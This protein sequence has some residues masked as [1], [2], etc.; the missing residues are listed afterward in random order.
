MKLSQLNKLLI[1]S[2]YLSILLH[3]LTILVIIYLIYDRYSY[4][5][6]YYINRYLFYSMLT[7][8]PSSHRNLLLFS[9]STLPKLGKNEHLGFGRPIIKKFLEP[10]NVKEILFITYA[11]PNV[12][13]GENTH[14]ADK[15]FNDL[16][17]PSFGKIG[18]KVKLL[19]TNSSAANQQQEIKNAQAVY[20]CGG[21]TF[22]LTQSL[23]K[24][25]VLQVL[26]ERI[27]SG[28]PYISASAGTNVTCPTMQTTND[29]PIACLN[30]CDT[31]NVIPFQMN[32]HYNEFKNKP[33][34]AAESRTQ[35]LCEY[36]QQNRLFKE[37]ETPTF[38][39]GLRE[40]SILHVSGDKAELLGLQSRKAVLMYLNNG[41]LNKTSI[42]IGER[43]DDLLK[44]KI[45][46]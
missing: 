25:G 46:V 3:I 9:S 35:R 11:S 45:S 29:M 6:E 39:L 20:M 38:I 28:M 1:K 37:T 33:G 44:L 41:V 22:L 5:P 36:L 43:V 34:F 42:N 17:V 30:S 26:K 10:H 4:I 23:H 8:T 32:V 12:R 15:L 21:N 24:Y 2:K 16:V 27:E 7:L 14:F 19:D 31:L 18:I 40:G 13:G